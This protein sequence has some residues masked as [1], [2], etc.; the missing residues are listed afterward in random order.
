MFKDQHKKNKEM[1]RQGL[2]ASVDEVYEA[3]ESKR[4]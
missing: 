2:E 1:M 3:F 4:A